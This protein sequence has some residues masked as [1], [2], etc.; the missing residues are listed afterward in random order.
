MIHSGP[1]G[2]RRECAR[3]VA[4]KGEREEFRADARAPR[5]CSPGARGLQELVEALQ[6]QNQQLENTLEEEGRR[7]E[8]AAKA[9]AQ[10]AEEAEQERSRMEAELQLMKATMA[11]LEN[12][13]AMLRLVG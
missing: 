13:N 6:L 10:K 1:S 2:K 11:E 3:R 8:A 5:G 4:E 9:A 7:W 12:E